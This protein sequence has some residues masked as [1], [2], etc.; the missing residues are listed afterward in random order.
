MGYDDDGR[1]KETNEQCLKATLLFFFFFPRS[2][3]HFFL[4]IVGPLRYA[5]LLL[6]R[7]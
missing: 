5:C 2:F 6:G 4:P 7:L 3:S 1:R